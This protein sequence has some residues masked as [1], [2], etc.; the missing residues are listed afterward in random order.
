MPSEPVIQ[1]PSKP[2]HGLQPNS[3]A[4]PPRG[5]AFDFA[6]WPAVDPSGQPT[7]ALFASARLPGRF[8]DIYGGRMEGAVNIV[9][10]EHQTG[11]VFHRHAEGGHMVPLAGAMNPNPAPPA[12]GV[13]Y[14]ES[15]DTYFAVDLRKQLTLPPGAANYATFLWL[16]EVA[17]P[18]RWVQLPGTQTPPEPLFPDPAAAAIQF[19]FTSGSPA[20]GAADIVLQRTAADMRVYGAVGPGVASAGAGPL[21]ILALDF[22]SRTLKWHALPL[23]GLAFDFDLLALFGGPGTFDP[24]PPPRRVFVV[25]ASRGAL[26]R[27]LVVEA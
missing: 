13:A 17:S 18:L 4:L 24:G 23:N 19:R 1:I 15:I 11:R 8:A 7:A 27:V 16:D 21:T 22:R 3:P 14:F 5:F 10:I 6:V 9:A 26:S 12:P 20:A 2:V 25:A